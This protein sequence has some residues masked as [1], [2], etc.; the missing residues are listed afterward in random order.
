MSLWDTYRSRIDSIGATKRDAKLRRESRYLS[1]KLPDNMSYFTVDIDGLTQDVAIVNTDNL[2]EKFIYSL[3][4][5]S[6]SPGGTVEWMNNHWLVTENDAANELYTR[7]KMIQCNYLLRWIDDDHIIHE[8]WCVI[9]DGTKYLTGQY[10]DREFFVTRGDS[11]IGMIIAKNE[12]TTKM[13]RGCRFLIDDEDSEM[14]LAYELSKPFKLSGVYNN[15]GIFKFVLQEVNTTDD[16][17]QDLRIADYYKHFPKSDGTT[18]P[19]NTIDPD[20]NT[21]EDGRKVWL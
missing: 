10:E 5:E 11:R 4:G 16:D 19:D 13:K 1:A 15:K 9:E 21:T 18:A 6:I 8:Q 3:P 14:M 20:S 17:N 12:Y 7:A 2:N